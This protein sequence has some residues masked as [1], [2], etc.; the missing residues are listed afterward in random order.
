MFTAHLA[1]AFEDVVGHLGVLLEDPALGFGVID[2]YVGVGRKV[3]DDIRGARNHV[4][5]VTGVKQIRLNELGGLGNRFEVALRE[6]IDGAYVVFRGQLSGEVGADEARGAGDD[7]VPVVEVHTPGSHG[8]GKGVV[9]GR[10]GTES[11]TRLPAGEGVC[12]TRRSC[13]SS[14][15][16]T[17]PAAT[18]E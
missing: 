12:T 16:A 4:R 11:A 17:G 8:S 1:H 15:W 6:V 7:D 5:H 3:E 13:V 14:G 10:G 2:A 9:V 18:T